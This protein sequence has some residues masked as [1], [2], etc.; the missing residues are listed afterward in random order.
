MLPEPVLC[1]DPYGRS[2]VI[3]TLQAFT[4]LHVVISLVAILAGLIV[5][6]GWL[7]TGGW[8]AGR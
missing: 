8:T 1:G 4:I 3:F 5:L 7:T 2:V 6:Y